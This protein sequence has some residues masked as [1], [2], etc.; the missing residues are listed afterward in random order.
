MENK[1]PCT[2]LLVVG[3]TLER[4]AGDCASIPGEMKGAGGISTSLLPCEL[5][6]VADHCSHRAVCHW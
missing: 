3:W 6:S 2:G 5:S 4:Q 1:N